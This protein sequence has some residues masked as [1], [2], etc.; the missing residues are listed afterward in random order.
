M[1][2]KG[3]S[4]HVMSIFMDIRGFSNFSKTNESPNIAIYV[5]KLFLKVLTDYFPEAT[6]A[7]PTGDG[8]LII[9]PYDEETLSEVANKVVAASLRCTEDFPELCRDDPMLNF[10]LPEKVGFGISRGLACCLFQGE[11]IID[12]SGHILNLAARLNG[13][14]R[15]SGVVIDGSFALAGLAGELLE[16]FKEDEI[17]L[18]G[19]ADDKAVSILYESRLVEISEHHRNPINEV[20]WV[21]HILKFKRSEFSTKKIFWKHDLPCRVDKAKGVKASLSFAVPRTK[22]NRS[23]FRNLKDVQYVEEPKRLIRFNMA[24]AHQILSENKIPKTAD[25]MVELAWVAAP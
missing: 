6:Y 22:T 19:V 20:K 16:Q 14:A 17:Y 2:A 8:L 18:K 1:K 15:P 13:V 5:K 7:K 4:E 25:V 11:I 10:A 3:R 24:E 12:Y 9:Y 21:T 23:R